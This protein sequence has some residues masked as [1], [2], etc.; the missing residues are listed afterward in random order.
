MWKVRRT[1][2]KIS[3]GGVSINSLYKNRQIKLL[4]KPYVNKIPSPGQGYL[5]MSCYGQRGLRGPKN[6]TSIAKLDGKILLLK[7]P[8]TLSVEYRKIKLE[9]S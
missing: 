6:N 3:K 5:F 2:D 1:P 4:Q 8:Y 7:K 9:L